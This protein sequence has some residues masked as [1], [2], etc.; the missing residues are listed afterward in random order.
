[1][2]GLSR[3]ATISGKLPCDFH[4]LS[5]NVLHISLASDTL[6]IIIDSKFTPEAAQEH[7]EAEKLRSAHPCQLH[8]YMGNLPNDILTDAC[9][10]M[11]L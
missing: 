7:F 8:A 4:E 2:T 11:L 6:K 5:Y 3:N 9:Q 1:M 10:M